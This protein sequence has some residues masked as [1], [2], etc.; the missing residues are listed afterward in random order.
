MTQKSAWGIVIVLVVPLI[1]YFTLKNFTDRDVSMPRRYLPDSTVTITKGGKQYTDTVWHKIADFNLLNQEGQQVSW[2]D[3]GGKVVVADFFF[4]HCPTICP[5]LTTVMRE[6]QQSI[7]SADRVGNRDPNFIHFLSFSID[8]ERDS[9][10]KLKWWA[11]RFQVDPQNWWLLTGDKKQIYDL[12]IREM[13]VPAEDG[14][15]VDSN[16]IHT[17]VFVLIDKHRNVRGYYHALLQEKENGKYVA[18]TASMQ[19]LSRDIVLLALEKE[20][21]EK[22]FLAGKLELIAVVFILAALAIVLL[23]KFLRREKS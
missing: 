18:D 13:R 1:A 4:T 6:L 16:F 3:L 12:S 5:T 17:D 15:V 2:K 23:F 11:D 7:K 8:P 14:G 22:F 19:R 21:G 20:K 9:V 10:E